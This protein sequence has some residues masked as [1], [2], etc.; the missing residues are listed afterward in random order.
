MSDDRDQATD[1]QDII[2]KLLAA[3]DGHP[4]AR[5]PWPHRVLHEAREAIEKLRKDN[6]RLRDALRDISA[7]LMRRWR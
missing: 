1:E 6:A 2:T 5:I 4:Y 3:C 7:I